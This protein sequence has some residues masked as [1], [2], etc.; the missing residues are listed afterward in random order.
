MAQNLTTGWSDIFYP[1]TA[2]GFSPNGSGR[3][4]KAD[5]YGDGIPGYFVFNPSR[6]MTLAGNSRF[7]Q[8]PSAAISGIT[9]DPETEDWTA[10]F[11]LGSCEERTV[12]YLV[13]N[14]LTYST[15]AG[16]GELSID[17][18][19][20]TSSGQSFSGTGEDSVPINIMEIDGM[21]VV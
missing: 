15:T 6:S 2:D 4:Y 20:A 9:Y 19:A 1:L 7:F 8:Y 10:I 18:D 21:E 12:S 5:P 17:A 3:E 16:T 13:G 11:F 14:T